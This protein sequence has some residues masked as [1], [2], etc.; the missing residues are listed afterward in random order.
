MIREELKTV[1][2]DLDFRDADLREVIR[3]LAEVSEINII[4]DE[5]ALLNM[6]QPASQPMQNFIA[7]I[8]QAPGIPAVGQPMQNPQNQY[9]QPQN[10]PYM[11]QQPGVNNQGVYNQN[12]VYNQN[13]AGIMPQQQN[14]MYQNSAQ[15]MP[16]QQNQ[17]NGSKMVSNTGNTATYQAPPPPKVSTPKITIFLKQIPLLT[18]LDIILRT[19]G[20]KYK[21][22]KDFIWI[23]TA[24][25]LSLEDLVTRI[26]TIQHAIGEF[27]NF[28]TESLDLSA[29]NIS[30]GD[31]VAGQFFNQSGSSATQ[32]YAPPQPQQQQTEAKAAEDLVSTLTK[33]VPQPQ[34]ASMTLYQRTGKL[35]VRN[36]P[37]TCVCLK[38]C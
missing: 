30:T 18:A 11:S 36:T 21:I 7:P 8:P 29:L 32:S 6:A 5:N 4:L 27:A 25:K 37:K 26:Y 15:N 2:I 23:S 1:L 35:I 13:Q 20:L 14:N 17:Q 12:P 33:I 38:V 31:N 22:E 10:N 9:P 3:Y 34:G 16:Q 28:E 24:D 19:K